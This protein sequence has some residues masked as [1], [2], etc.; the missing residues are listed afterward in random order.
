MLIFWI[1]VRR[2]YL[3]LS[4]QADTARR[5][6]T[7]RYPYFNWNR[8]FAL[9]PRPN[10]RNIST[11]HIAT[12]LAATCCV[13]LATLL[14]RVATCWVLLA[15]IWKW[16]NFS[17]NICGCSMMLLLFGQVHAI[18]LR[19]GMGISSIFNSQ[20]VATCYYRQCC[21]LLRSNVAIIWPELA[22]AEPTMLGYV[23]LW[24]CDRLAET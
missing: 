13:R 17:C 5:N 2:S 18:M 23:A 20:H 3:D 4:F 11:Q 22:N 14:R 24:C 8:S 16:S 15:Q 9:K 19:L 6:W 21:D 10:D 12:L 1:K 7:W